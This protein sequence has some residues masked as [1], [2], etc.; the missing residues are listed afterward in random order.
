M[1]GI[2]ADKDLLARIEGGA[3]QAKGKKGRFDARQK[4]Y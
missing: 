4:G 1:E 2:L 3:K